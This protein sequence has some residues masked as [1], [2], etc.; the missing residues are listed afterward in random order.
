MTS[1][2]GSGFFFMAHLKTAV[3]RQWSVVSNNNKNNPLKPDEDPPGLGV[4][5]FCLC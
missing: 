1:N 5:A 3:S 2:A 4:K